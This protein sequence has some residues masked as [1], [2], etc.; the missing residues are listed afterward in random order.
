MS[1]LRRILVTGGAGLI[2][3]H[4]CRRLL[5]EDHDLDPSNETIARLNRKI[6]G[7]RKSP[8][9]AATLS[10]LPRI[11]QFY[12]VE[13]LLGILFTA[14]YAGFMA[15]S[16]GSRMRMESKREDYLTANDLDMATS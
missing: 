15:A 11:G 8:L 3:S 14:A 12:N 6:L 2:G 13:T 10:L 4:L 16:I 1:T 9:L 7:K 5:K